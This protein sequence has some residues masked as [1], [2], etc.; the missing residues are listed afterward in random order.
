MQWKALLTY[1]REFAENRYEN[2]ESMAL[3]AITKILS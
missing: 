3:S 2:E 1:V